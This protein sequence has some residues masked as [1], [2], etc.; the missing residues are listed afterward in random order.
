MSTIR[1][2]FVVAW[3]GNEPVKVRTNAWD[4]VVAADQAN[5]A[6][7]TFALVHNALHRDKT[8]DLPKLHDFIGLIDEF[9]DVSESSEPNPMPRQV[10]TREPSPYPS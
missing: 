6:M 1:R 9:E 2:E 3:N 7:M 4:M 5:K 10:L 8:P